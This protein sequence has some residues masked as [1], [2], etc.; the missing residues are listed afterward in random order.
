MNQSTTTTKQAEA[1]RKNTIALLESLSHKSAELELP[2]PPEV[3]GQYAQKL[4][5]NTYKVLVA[6]EAKRGKSSFVNALIGQDILPTA[7]QVA[8]SQVFEVRRAPREAYRLRFEDDSVREV[9]PEDLPRY[10]SQV[11]EDAGERPELDQIIRW[12]EVDTPAIRFLPAGVSLLDTPGLGA[13]HAAHAQI[14]RR[15]VPQADAVIFVLDSEKQIVQTE[16][17]FVDAI[18]GVS[19]DIFFIQTKIDLHREEDWRD[20]QSRNRQILEERFENRLTDTRVWPISS[21]LLLAAA[22]GGDDAQEDLEDSRHKDLELALQAFLFRVAGW[23]RSATAVVLADDYHTT[24]RQMLARRLATLESSAQRRAEL[25]QR[26]A[27]RVRQF[28]LDWGPQGQERQKLVEGVRR[29]VAE[30]KGSIREAVQPG[31]RIDAAARARI[32]AAGP[33]EETEQLFTA[34][35]GD[36]S[37]QAVDEWHRTWELTQKRCIE[38]LAPFMDA[39][40]EISATEYSGSYRQMERREPLRDV[41]AQLRQRLGRSHKVLLPAG[42]VVGIALAIFV[43]PAAAARAAASAA[44]VAASLFGVAAQR[45]KSLD[46]KHKAIAKD[47]LRGLSDFALQRVRSQLLEGDVKSGQGGMVDEEFTTLERE[48]LDQVETIVRRKEEEARAE[49]A[50]LVEASRFDDRQRQEGVERTRRQLSEWEAIGATIEDLGARLS[51]LDQSLITTSPS[52]GR[53]T[54]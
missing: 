1:V 34:M 44:K 20:V 10:G 48:M 28:E 41:Q 27:S 19:S 52:T 3:L 29:I 11:L 37:A 39:A 30:G 46:E 4:R 6:G 36:L 16:L 8:T 12:I 7:V 22:A 25:Q 32:E 9:T 54:G 24:S 33:V 50:H 15:F 42:A 18:L 23:S 14:T 40:D 38:L 53:A 45:Y 49:Y 47:R 21:T 26:A 51:A 31:G 43:G 17:D 35:P 5:E 13:L 2:Q